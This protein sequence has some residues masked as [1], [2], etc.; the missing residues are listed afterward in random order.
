M[1]AQRKR[2]ALLFC[3]MF[4]QISRKSP[5]A[6]QGVG[7]V[8]SQCRKGE[9]TQNIF[10][11]CP[12]GAFFWKTFCS[13]WFSLEI[14][15]MRTDKSKIC[16]S[17]NNQCY[18]CWPPKCQGTL[19]MRLISVTSTM[20]GN[21]IDGFQ[22]TETGP[23]VG[24]VLSY[25][26]RCRHTAAKV[27]LS[28]TEA[29]QNAWKRDQLSILLTHLHRRTQIWQGSAHL[30]PQKLSLPQL[31]FWKPSFTLVHIMMPKVAA[32]F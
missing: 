4:I 17:K 3:K 30:K 26:N 29:I 9:G 23:L 5:S 1:A 19:V 27:I 13:S 32:S 21:R 25:V 14:I 16:C 22:S 18:T 24:L 31:T 15:V 2:S 6:R 12:A 11:C 10:P 8:L 28:P 20:W 7:V